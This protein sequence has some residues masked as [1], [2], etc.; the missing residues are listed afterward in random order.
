MWIEYGGTACTRDEAAKR[1]HQWVHDGD[2]GKEVEEGG[3]WCSTAPAHTGAASP[4]LQGVRFCAN[5]LP[6]S[7]GDRLSCVAVLDVLNND[8]TV[9][10]LTEIM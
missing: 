3:V 9:S 8:I 2:D 7:R 1:D 5:S 4:H 10:V 6:V